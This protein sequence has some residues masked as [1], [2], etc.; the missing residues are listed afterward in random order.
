MQNREL[1]EDQDVQS[2]INSEQQSETSKLQ[3]LSQISSIRKKDS[4]STS[5]LD[6]KI[7]DKVD[8]APS[9]AEELSK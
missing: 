8:K 7:L 4:I 1:N 5:G 2:E 9:K 3:N 6:L